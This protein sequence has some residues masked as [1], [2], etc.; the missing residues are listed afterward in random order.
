VESKKKITI[1]N[2]KGRLSKEEIERM[3]NDAEKF[4]AED[5]KQREKVAAR[6]QL[7][8]YLFGVKQA[9]EEASADKLSE[10]DKSKVNDKCR[11]ILNWLDN[12][13]LADKE[14]FEYKLKEVQKELQPIMMKL[15]GG[16]TAGGGAPGGGNF[17]GSQQ[18]A[19][20]TVEEV[21]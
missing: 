8:G 13:Q 10:S 21:D 2:D 15:H 20:P 6:N 1:K 16:G 7:E 5:D 18:S 4:K 11:E 14:E 17:G 9:A 19:G 3:V 12:N